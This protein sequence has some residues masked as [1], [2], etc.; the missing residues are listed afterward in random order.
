MTPEINA[1]LARIETDLAFV[2]EALIITTKPSLV[3]PTNVVNGRYVVEKRNFTEEEAKA[4]VEAIRKAERDGFIDGDKRRGAIMRV[5]VQTVASPATSPLFALAE[6]YSP[7]EAVIAKKQIDAACLN[8]EFSSDK[9]RG[10]KRAVT[11]R[12]VS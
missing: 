12:T 11:C 9:R 1:A 6:T 2:R 7:D 3:Q 10:L 8:G 5:T 4:E